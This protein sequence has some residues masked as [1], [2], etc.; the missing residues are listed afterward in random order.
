MDALK[1]TVGQLMSGQHPEV[2]I[3]NYFSNNNTMRENCRGVLESKDGKIPPKKQNPYLLFKP[4][5][6]DLETENTHTPS[7]TGPKRT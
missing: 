1:K 2:R 6:T 3:P 4:E 5:K 7:S